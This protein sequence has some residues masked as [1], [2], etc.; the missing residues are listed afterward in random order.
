MADSRFSTEKWYKGEFVPILNKVTRFVIVVV[1]GVILWSILTSESYTED[2]RWVLLILLISVGLWITEAIPPFAVGML[3]IGYL[4]F[5]MGGTMDEGTGGYAAQYVNTWSSPVIWLMLGGFFIA[6]GMK[7]VELDKRLFRVA[8]SVFGTQPRMVLLGMMTTTA[9]FSMIMSNTSTSAMMI[10]AVLPFVKKTRGGPLS[11]ALLLG[12]PVAASVGGMGTIIGSPPNAI[13][14]GAMVNY[15][16]NVDFVEWM[17]Y[18]LPAAIL[19]V[20]FFWFVLCRLYMPGVGHVEL[21]IEIKEPDTVREIRQIKYVIVTIILTVLLWLTTPL[22]HIHVAAIAMIPIVFLT[23]S[24]VIK[25]D[26]VRQIPWDTLM[27]VAGGLALGLAIVDTG[28]ANLFVSNIQQYINLDQI[29]LVYLIFA[30]ICVIM[31]N[32]MS[33]TAIASILVPIAAASVPGYE[34][35]I[36]VIIGLSASTALLLPVSTPPNAIAY[37]TG[38]LKQSDFRLGGITIGILGP[39]LVTIWVSLIYGLIGG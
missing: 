36:S 7:Q 16:I 26:Q 34:Y 13:A 1:V 4:V 17:L 39:I 29:Y 9:I 37:S 8:S 22:H 25:A 10:G 21:D 5:T 33:N 18:G 12:I 6:E 27:L 38:F 23:V 20:L 2:Q 31:S 14:V 35:Q 19:L 30:Y 11:K 24:G 15:G 3:I 32:F 28:L